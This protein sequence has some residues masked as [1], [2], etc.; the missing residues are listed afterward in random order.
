ME[1]V[2]DTTKILSILEGYVDALIPSKDWWVVPAKIAFDQTAWS[3]VWNS[4][5][6]VVLGLLRFESPEN[7][8]NEL[9]TTFL[10]LL[11][12]GWKLWPFAHLITY[13]VI[14]LEQRL[15]WVDCV[16]LIWVTILS[17]FVN[18]V[19]REL[20][21]EFSASRYASVQDENE[22]EPGDKEFRG[23]GH[24]WH[25]CG[26]KPG[27][28]A[29]KI[30][31]WDLTLLLCSNGLSR[32]ESDIVSQ[33][34]AIGS[35]D[36]RQCNNACEN[37]FSRFVM[38]LLPKLHGD[39]NGD[40]Y[41]TKKIIKREVLDIVSNRGV[42]ESSQSHSSD[43]GWKQNFSI[44]EIAV[45][46]QLPLVGIMKRKK[47]TEVKNSMYHLSAKFRLQPRL[48]QM[49]MLKDIEIPT[50]SGQ[51]VQ[52]NRNV[53]ASTT[54]PPNAYPLLANFSTLE[55]MVLYCSENTMRPQLQVQLIYSSY[56]NESCVMDSIQSSDQGY[57]S[58]NSISCD[59][60]DQSY[61]MPDHALTELDALR[62]PESFVT[63]FN[64]DIPGPRFND[65]SVAYIKYVVEADF[66]VRKSCQKRLRNG[67]GNA[68]SLC[69]SFDHN[70][71]RCPK[72]FEDQEQVV[73]KLEVV[74][75]E[76]KVLVQEEEDLVQEYEDLVQ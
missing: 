60:V 1:L 49:R 64:F 56:F 27:S 46:W 66:V 75:Q 38:L 4:I 63:H 58:Q 19:I 62:T 22:Y 59:V 73:V 69:G 55:K 18:C 42:H 14:P 29:S 41:G 16:E 32:H 35:T 45:Y 71:R 2:Q 68:Y 57:V 6:F 24:S 36:E 30:M 31:L 48:L 8:F 65:Y 53:R 11:T 7:I 61:V 67:N 13:G 76:K 20:V 10:P 33:A 21:W 70:K 47:S 74:V 72:R 5:Y 54:T 39:G 51:T 25:Y 28:C 17:T 23:A 12:A 44:K 50:S 43:G 40:G 3:A 37:M 9:K 34:L 52:G 26:Y 15:L